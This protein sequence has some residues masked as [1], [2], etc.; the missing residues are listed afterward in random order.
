MRIGVAFKIKLLNKEKGKVVQIVIFTITEITARMR[1]KKE[2][3]AQSESSLAFH[4]KAEQT[5]VIIVCESDA[6]LTGNHS[7]PHTSAKRLFRLQ[8]L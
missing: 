1:K 4:Y 8:T 5:I 7:S 2:E 6:K 3:E